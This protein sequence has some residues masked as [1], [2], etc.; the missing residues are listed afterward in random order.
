M[1]GCMGGSSPRATRGGSRRGA[2]VSGGWKDIFEP[3]SLYVELQDHGLPEQSVLNG[4]LADMAQRLS[5]PL[6]ATNDV[7]YA[8]ASDAEAHLYLSCIKPG[9]PPPRRRS[10]TRV[11]RDAPQV[12]RG[13]GRAL[14]V[15]PGCH[16]GDAGDLPSGAATGS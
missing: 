4:L 8:E 12:P 13:D 6:V 9:A 3:G 5:L 1:T 15:L 10:G 16:Q 7:H 11:E 2:R 14:R